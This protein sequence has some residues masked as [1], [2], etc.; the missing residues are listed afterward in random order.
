MRETCQIKLHRH[1][2]FSND[3]ILT[4]D[5]FT[6]GSLTFT[7][8]RGMKLFLIVYCVKSPIILHRKLRIR[9]E[10]L[11]MFPINSICR[12]CMSVKNFLTLVYAHNIRVVKKCRL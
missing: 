7:F 5:L 3:P 9:F 11:L 8:Q 1:I 6:L 2:S 10:R 12:K 4:P